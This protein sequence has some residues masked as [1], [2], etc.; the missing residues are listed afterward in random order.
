MHTFLTRNVSLKMI[1][2]GRKTVFGKDHD[3]NNIN[4]YEDFIKSVPIRD[5]E[6]FKP[7]IE[8]I[9]G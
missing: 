1:K 3:F 7:Y 5:Y 8:Q 2:T 9:M 6:A 4:S